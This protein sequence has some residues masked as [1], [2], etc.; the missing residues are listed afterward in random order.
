M[1]ALLHHTKRLLGGGYIL[2]SDNAGETL[3][4]GVLDTLE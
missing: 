4:D 3:L 1:R 2:L